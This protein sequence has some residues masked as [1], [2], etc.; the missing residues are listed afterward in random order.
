MDVGHKPSDVQVD[1]MMCEEN[2]FTHEDKNEYTHRIFIGSTSS[3]YSTD[4]A[5]H[6]ISEVTVK[7]DEE[8]HQHTILRKKVVNDVMLRDHFFPAGIKFR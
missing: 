8:I 6:Q 7:H 1:N 4:V 3:L 2:Q 5:Y